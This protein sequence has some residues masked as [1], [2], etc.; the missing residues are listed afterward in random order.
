MVL[1]T[2]GVFVAF[3]DHAG[4]YILKLC[5]WCS[6]DLQDKLK[7]LPVLTLLAGQVFYYSSLGQ[8]FGAV[9]AW[10]CSVLVLWYPF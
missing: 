3:I 10:E 9:T 5:P 4:V 7:Q 6:L 2:C 8:Q 1:I